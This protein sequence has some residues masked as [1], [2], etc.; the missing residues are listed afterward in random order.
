MRNDVQRHYPRCI[1]CLKT[2]IKA[3]SHELYTPSPF[4]NVPWEDI[5]LDFIIELPW[6]TKGI[7]SIF[8]N[9][10]FSRDVI[11]LHSLSPSIV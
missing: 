8:M 4:A 5:S 1:S 11:G 6:T 10:L 9:K 3:M 2:K 7:N